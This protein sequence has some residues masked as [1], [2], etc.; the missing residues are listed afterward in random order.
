VEWFHII[1]EHNDLADERANRAFQRE[2]YA[3]TLLGMP[4]PFLDLKVLSPLAPK[5]KLKKYK[6]VHILGL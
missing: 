6:K 3:S 4:S 1:H 2:F 5:F